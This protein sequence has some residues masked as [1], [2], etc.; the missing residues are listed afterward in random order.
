VSG[1]SNLSFG[2]PLK[3]YTSWDYNF[4]YTQRKS[5]RRATLTIPNHSF[6][7]IW[8]GRPWKFLGWSANYQ[9]KFIRTEQNGVLSRVETH[10]FYGGMGVSLTEKW[11]VD[12]NRGITLTKTPAK[13]STL[14]YLSV[15]TALRN[16]QVRENIE[17]TASFRRTY[18]LHSD[19]GRYALNLFYLSSYM[20]LYPEMEARVDLTINYNDNPQSV[21][22]RYQMVKS[23]NLTTK[24]RRN[25]WLDLDY[26]TTVRGERIT[27]TRT[28]IENL[29]LD[30]TYW[31]KGNFSLRTGY[32]ANLY[33]WRDTP[34]SYSFSGEVSYPYRNIFSSSV[35]YVRRWTKD[36][37]TGKERSTDDLNSQLNFFLG[38]GA[39]LTLT[40]YVADLKKA[41]STSV[42]GMI[43]TQRF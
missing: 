14:D 27:L 31:G 20:T 1:E 35:I 19:M 34:N 36:P 42:L 33:N 25:L 5:P 15:M 13:K 12:L 11:R 21:G 23:L 18:Y 16:L 41:T 39:K 43:L 37:R 9:G 10:S 22:G 30:L 2:L 24:P 29:S 40:Y 38:K 17:A 3:T 7:T 8:S 6:S 32:Q 4:S 28:E 26:Q